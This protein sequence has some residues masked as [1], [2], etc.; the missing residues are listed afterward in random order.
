ML[1]L[2]QRE[3]ACVS[4]VRLVY[5]FQTGLGLAE[6]HLRHAQAHA[7]RHLHE[8]YLRSCVHAGVECTYT[9]IMQCPEQT[10]T[11]NQQPTINNQPQ[12]STNN[13]QA[14]TTNNNNPANAWLKTLVHLCLMYTVQHATPT[15]DIFLTF[16]GSPVFESLR[17]STMIV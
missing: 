8:F 6:D 15:T 16:S 12:P 14:T 1:K 3:G 13:H 2:T 5:L 9:H 7:S 4:K 17:S 11:N 10:N